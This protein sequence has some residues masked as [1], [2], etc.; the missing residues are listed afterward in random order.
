M[1][2]QPGAEGMD[3]T[4]P[5]DSTVM[6]PHFGNTVTARLP[7]TGPLISISLSNKSIY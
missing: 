2:P 1:Y 6:I 4:M 7:N 3:I 5:D